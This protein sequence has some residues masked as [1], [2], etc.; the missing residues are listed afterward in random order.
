MCFLSERH[1][2]EISG[3]SALSFG[4][5]TT[6][7]SYFSVGQLIQIPVLRYTGTTT[8]MTLRYFYI[9]KVLR[10]R[11]IVSHYFYLDSFILPCRP[12]PILPLRYHFGLSQSYSHLSPFM[13]RKNS[14]LAVVFSSL[15]FDTTYI[16]S[17]VYG[18]I[19]GN[20]VGSSNN[21]KPIRPMIR[22]LATM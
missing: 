21:E 16:G 6:G 11:Y 15:L 19:C 22:C 2:S 18:F 5:G 17:P 7:F 3:I 1:W 12:W 13:I 14:S 20:H 4:T 9:Y 10:F 8:Y